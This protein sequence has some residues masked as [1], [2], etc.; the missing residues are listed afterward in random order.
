MKEHA[1]LTLT[2]VVVYILAQINIYIDILKNNFCAFWN[3]RV[4]LKFKT[5]QVPGIECRLAG[6]TKNELMFM[7]YW[8]DI[9]G[10]LTSKHTTS[11]PRKLINKHS[12]TLSS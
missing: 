4:N 2:S 11:P 8:V 9:H 7:N 12:F 6:Q 10:F 1:M 3:F 5:S